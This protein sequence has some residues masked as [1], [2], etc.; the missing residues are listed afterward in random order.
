MDNFTWTDV[1]KAYRAEYYPKTKK[2]TTGGNKMITE[3]AFRFKNLKMK[4][5]PRGIVWT[6]DI[7]Y[8]GE[9]VGDVCDD[10]ISAVP[11]YSFKSIEDE[12]RFEEWSK[13]YGLEEWL[14]IDLISA[15]IYALDK[16]HAYEVEGVY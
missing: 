2:E 14:D 12:K 13:N 11:H 5:W 9:V 7:L 6:A 15:G 16:I 8:N 10:A 1:V 4:E 3:K